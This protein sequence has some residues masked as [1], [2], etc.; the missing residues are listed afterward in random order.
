MLN[1]G[2]TACSSAAMSLHDA[3]ADISANRTDY[4]VVLGSCNIQAPNMTL[5]FNNLHMLSPE[6]ACKAFDAAGNGYVDM[7]SI[8]LL[9]NCTS[10]SLIVTQHTSHSGHQWLNRSYLLWSEGHHF[11]ASNVRHK[12]EALILCSVS[13]RQVA[14]QC[15]LTSACALQV[16]AI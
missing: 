15:F 16:C 10:A 12:D 5:A 13:C 4:A 9:N 6:G 2:D 14:D 3:I 8:F 11:L 1:A 7:I